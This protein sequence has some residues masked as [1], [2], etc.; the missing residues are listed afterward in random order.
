[1]TAIVIVVV[2][3]VAYFSSSSSSA[4]KPPTAITSLPSIEELGVKPDPHEEVDG[5]VGAPGAGSGWSFWGTAPAAAQPP[6]PSSQV[7]GKRVGEQDS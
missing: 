1:M 7:G 5:G 6:T 2:S 4:S 3:V